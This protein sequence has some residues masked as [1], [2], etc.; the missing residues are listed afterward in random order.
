MDTAPKANGCFLGGTQEIFGAVSED[1]LRGT[2]KPEDAKLP[3]AG[4]IPKLCPMERAGTERMNRNKSCGWEQDS[5]AEKG[6][7]KQPRGH[8]PMFVLDTLC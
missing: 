6:G 5:A 1:F 4:I 8:H 3:G 2:G 7:E